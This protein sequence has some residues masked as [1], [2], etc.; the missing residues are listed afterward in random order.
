MSTTLHIIFI[1]LSI[2]AGEIVNIFLENLDLPADFDK[3]ERIHEALGEQKDIIN[4]INSWYLDYNNYM[5]EYFN[6]EDPAS[7]EIFPS[8]FTQ[9]LY[10]SSGSKHR[11]LMEFKD[12]IVCGQP[13]PSLSVS[14]HIM[15]LSQR[16]ALIWKLLLIFKN[17][18]E[19]YSLKILPAQFTLR[20]K[21]NNQT[22][23]G[24]MIHLLFFLLPPSLMKKDVYISLNKTH[25]HVHIYLF[26]MIYL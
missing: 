8:R 16:E 7:P 26:I 11:L 18:L 4:N 3:L 20:L 19:N 21:R 9:F 12:D 22:I 25:V 6:N 17:I 1:V 14:K 24:P 23:I 5:G 13:S 15:I 10:G 2:F